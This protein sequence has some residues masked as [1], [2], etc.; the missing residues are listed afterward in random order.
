MLLLDIQN[1]RVLGMKERDRAV[2][3]VAFGHEIFAA[4]I[5]VRVRAENRNFRADVMRRMQSAFAQDVRG[6]RRGRRLAVHSGDDDAAFA[7]HD[8]GER[9]GATHGWLAA[10]ARAHENRI[11]ALDRGGINDELGVAARLRRDAVHENADR[12]AAVDLFP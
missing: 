5:P 4:R 7:P 9:F 11:V 12:A 3:L 6:H 8:G 2:A 1:E 10:I